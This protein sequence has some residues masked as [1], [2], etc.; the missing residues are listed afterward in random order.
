MI[1]NS[2]TGCKFQI[3][4]QFGT[5]VRV[6]TKGVRKFRTNQSF[7]LPHFVGATYVASCSSSVGDVANVLEGGVAVTGF[8]STV[9]PPQQCAGG[10][11]AGGRLQTNYGLLRRL[12]LALFLCAQDGF[13]CAT[14]CSSFLFT[15][16][17]SNGLNATYVTSCS[18][19]VGDVANVLEGGVA[20]TGFTSTVPPPQQCRAKP[21]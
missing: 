18:S 17:N 14:R 20:V 11:R 1:E 3:I 12:L 13:C 15:H 4:P 10:G 5:P 2:D 6:S 7:C 19:S 16:R 8:T 9:P 21:V